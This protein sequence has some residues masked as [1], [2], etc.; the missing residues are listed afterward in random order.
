MN[1]FM[2]QELGAYRDNGSIPHHG[3]AIRFESQRISLEGFFTGPT[4]TVIHIVQLV[5]RV[6]FAN[7]QFIAVVY[8]CVNVHA[9]LAVCLSS[10]S[11]QR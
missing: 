8:E 6:E 10:H 3:S 7:L 9:L 2:G 1:R 11:A 5:R 4:E